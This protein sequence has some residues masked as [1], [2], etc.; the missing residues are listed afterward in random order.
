M[1]HQYFTDYGQEIL[2]PKK[3]DNLALFQNRKDQKALEVKKESEPFP[4]LSTVSSKQQEKDQKE[5][6]RGIQT[7]FRTTANNHMNLSGMAD[8][9]ASIMI[10]VNTLILGLAVPNVI[11]RIDYIEWYDLVPIILLV[12]TCLISITFAVLAT[13]PSVNKGRFTE[14]DIRNKKTNLLF[15]GNFH[16]MQLT[17]Y[18]WG[19]NQMIKDKEYLYNTMMM[20]V[21]FLGVVLAKKYRLLRISYTVFMIG[22]ILTVIGFGIA[23]FT[24]DASTTTPTETIDF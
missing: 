11:S 15:F 5:T 21:Y 7:M 18:Q 2:T 8:N 3:M 16:Q 24:P 23:A 20:D 4:Y 6:E 1:R 9:K 22:L 10:T 19:M 17:D 13:R 14:E 12:L